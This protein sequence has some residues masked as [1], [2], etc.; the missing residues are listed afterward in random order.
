MNDPIISVRGLTVRRGD[1]T[2]LDGVDLDIARGEVM[3][4]LG[5][6]G[7]GKSL[8]LKLTGP[9]RH[10]DQPGPGTSSQRSEA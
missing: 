4:L 1:R 7:S 8:I 9:P 5:G 3:V 10:P 2:V 6:S